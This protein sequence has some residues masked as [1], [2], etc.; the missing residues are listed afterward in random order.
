MCSLLA[1]QL[2]VL[3]PWTLF[4]LFVFYLFY[5][6]AVL[7]PTKFLADIKYAGQNKQNEWI[8]E[9]NISKIQTQ[10]LINT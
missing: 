10:V 4:G 2:L 9:S 3:K 6:I 1:T 5:S 8:F 7:F